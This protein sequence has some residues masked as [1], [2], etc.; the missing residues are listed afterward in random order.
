MAERAEEQ[1]GKMR[2]VAVTLGDFNKL[3][4]LSYESIRIDS[5]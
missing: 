3:E 5:R 4:E 2:C 1:G